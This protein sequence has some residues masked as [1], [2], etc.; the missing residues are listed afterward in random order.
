MTQLK[1]YKKIV[2]RVFE[3]INESLDDSKNP[4]EIKVYAMMKAGLE[5]SV[6]HDIVE[7]AVEQYRIGALHNF[8]TVSKN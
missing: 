6:T 2:N 3:I 5:L 8:S 4:Q 7:N 1:L